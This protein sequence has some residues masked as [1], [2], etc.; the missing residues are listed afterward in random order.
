MRKR[1]PK[2]AN[3]DEIDISYAQYIFDNHGIK[4][5]DMSQPLLRT[6]GRNKQRIFLVPELCLISEM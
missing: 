3:E 6:S 2:G 4:V 5:T 1:G